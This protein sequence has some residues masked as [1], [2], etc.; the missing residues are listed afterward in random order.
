MSVQVA[1]AVDSLRR[2]FE[3]PR[4]SDLPEGARPGTEEEAYA[5]QTA[6]LDGEPLAGWKV[7]PSPTGTYRCAPLGR[8]RLI[9]DGGCLPA[10]L[11][12]PLVEVELAIRLDAEVTDTS[13]P[14]AL[15]AAGRVSVALEILDS[16]F[17]DRKAVSPLTALAD[18]QSNRAFVVG[19]GSVPWDGVEFAETPLRLLADGREI[20]HTAGGA[21]TAAVRDALIW[22]VRH[23]AGRRLPL[24][25]G[26]S[27]ITGSRIGPLPLP[28]CRCLTAISAGVGEVTV[29]MP[30]SERKEPRT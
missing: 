27:L 12:A 25:A 30:P 8:S 6:L 23:A 10:G 19:D 16:R 15:I 14:A 4:L 21:S 9:A 29:E 17:L 11:F 22:L 18:A 3:G 24:R 26:Q 2:A 1:L 5:V 13:D 20:A 28:E 7:A